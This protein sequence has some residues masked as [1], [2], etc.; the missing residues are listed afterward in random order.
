VKV[1]DH[2]SQ[3]IV[4]DKA[5]SDFETLMLEMKRLTSFFIQHNLVDFCFESISTEESIS[6]DLK[7]P[8]SNQSHMKVNLNNKGSSIQTEIIVYKLMDFEAQVSAVEG[9]ADRNV[10]QDLQTHDR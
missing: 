10:P 2:Q 6:Q 1:K 9:A 7:K 8:N 4:Y 3:E 5:L